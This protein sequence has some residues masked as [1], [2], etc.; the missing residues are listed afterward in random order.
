MS[1][2]AFIFIARLK[3]AYSAK[4]QLVLKNQLIF[5]LPLSRNTFNQS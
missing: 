3:N 4:R 2:L 1:L 5:L